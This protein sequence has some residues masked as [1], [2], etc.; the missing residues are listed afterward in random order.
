LLGIGDVF[1]QFSLSAN[2]GIR[3]GRAFRTITDQDYPGR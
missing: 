1:P 3:A 2:V